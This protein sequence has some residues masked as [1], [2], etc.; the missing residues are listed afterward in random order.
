MMIHLVLLSGGS[1]TR[2]WPLSNNARSKQFLKVLRDEDG[3]PV[4]MVQRVFTQIGRIPAKVSTTIATCASQRSAIERQLEGDFELV[5]EPE[6]R[7]TAPAI[8]LACAHLAFEQ[9][10]SSDD[11]VVVMPIDT[12]AEQA[13]Y[14]QVITLDSAVQEGTAELVLLGVRPTYP[15][16]KYGYIAPER[17]EGGVWPVACFKEKPTEAEAQALIGQGAL[18]NCGVFAFKLAYLMNVIK[19]Y[20]CPTSYADVIERYADLPK[21]SF[22]YEVVEKAAGVAVVPYGGVWKDLGTWNTLTEEMVEATSGRVVGVDT[23]ESTH[24]IN[25]LGLPLVTLG[26]KNVAVVATPDGILVSEKTCS[27]HMKPYVGQ[28]AEMRPMYEQRQWGEYRVLDMSAF[29]QARKALSKELVIRKGKQLSYQ[30]HKHRREIWVVISGSGEVVLD[31]ITRAVCVGSVVEI[32]ANC[33]HSARA[34]E[35][36]HVVEV[37]LGG[38]LEEEDIER[39][40]MY[41]DMPEEVRSE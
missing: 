15:S 36:L 31:G 22:D 35:D 5:L 38:S 29:S 10:V 8:M 7:D 27:S 6:R 11:T 14:N 2:L 19:R 3:S 26:L 23:C 13:Y 34:F 39:F 4:S 21:N 18:W 41:W 33:K 24:V 12:F 37:Q 20:V 28:I 32:E 17:C 30:R 16:E 25:E 40:G 1:G 9:H